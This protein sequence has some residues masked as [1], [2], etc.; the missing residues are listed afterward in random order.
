L[1][2]GKDGDNL[3]PYQVAKRFL[4]PKIEEEDADFDLDDLTIELLKIHKDVYGDEDD[5]NT[6]H[7]KDVAGKKAYAGFGKRQYKGRCTKCGKQGHKAADCRSQASNYNNERSGKQSHYNNERSGKQS[8]STTR[9]KAN[10]K[11]SA[12]TATL[13]D[14]RRPT[15]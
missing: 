12:T 13:K 10:F 2:G 11:A 7:T 9:R 1:P 8:R 3:G 4:E 14:T 6:K 5:D 15:V